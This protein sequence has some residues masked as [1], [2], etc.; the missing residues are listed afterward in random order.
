M[1][2]PAAYFMAGNRFS[3]GALYTLLRNT[4]SGLA[5]F[6]AQRT[7]L[8]PVSRKIE[9]PR[10]L[11]PRPYK[12]RPILQVSGMHPASDAE[13]VEIEPRRREAVCQVR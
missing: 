5:G 11:R 3:R 13:V 8:H 1:R 9:R 7:R 2:K 6:H 4:A 12:S 10:A